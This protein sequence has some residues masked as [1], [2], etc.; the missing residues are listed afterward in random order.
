MACPHERNCNL[1]CQ[2]FYAPAPLARSTIFT[3]TV[4]YCSWN[5]YWKHKKAHLD[6]EWAKT[7]LTWHYEHHMGKDQNTNWCVTHPFFDHVMGT[8]KPFH[9]PELSTEK[10]MLGAQLGSFLNRT[11]SRQ[12]RFQLFAKAT[13]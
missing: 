2:H 5:Y 13:R 8:R 7:S 10:K 12:S 3:A 9:D 1:R 4:F 6:P 11:L